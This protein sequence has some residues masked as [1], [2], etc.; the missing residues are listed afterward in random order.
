MGE[1]IKVLSK[2]PFRGDDLLIELNKESA[3]GQEKAIHIQT[4]NF[5]WD[6]PQSDFLKVG[7][8]TLAAIDKLKKIKEL[9]K[10]E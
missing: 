6:M 8:T 9:N 4:S 7:F 5:R 10:D 3:K 2:T 1:V